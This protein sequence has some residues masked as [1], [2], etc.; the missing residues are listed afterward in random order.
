MTRV[1]R[2]VGIGGGHGLATT[3]RAARTYADEITAIVSVADDGGSSGRLRATTGLPAMGD[4]RRCLTTLAGPSDAWARSLERRFH[5]GPLDGH[6]LGNL[7]LTALAEE[8]GD[9]S[10]AVA[11]VA[12][13]L[14]LRATVLPTTDVAVTLVADTEA[15]H[16]VGQVAVQST[17]G[18]KRVALEPED[19]PP[20][21]GVVAAIGGADQIV[22]GPGSLFTSVLA[23]LAVPAVRRAVAR[24]SAQRVYVCN[25]RTEPPETAGFDVAAHLAALRNHDVAIDVVLCDP[26]ALPRG[27]VDAEVVELPLV[28]GSSAAHDPDLLGSA[29]ASLMR[30]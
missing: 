17:S 15:G 6:P 24:S 9:L 8:L 3:L 2:V 27:A 11:A 25:L 4:L 16:V 7:V 1:A 21:A 26:R 20:A 18:I 30:D 19:P 29:L 13:Q 23:A 5:G 14:D 12:A 22:I 28:R 10:A